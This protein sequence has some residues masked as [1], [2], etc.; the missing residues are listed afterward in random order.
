ML[1]WHNFF[2]WF[3]FCWKRK[4]REFATDKKTHGKNCWFT[5]SMLYILIFLDFWCSTSRKI[6][7]H[8]LNSHQTS[9]FSAFLITNLIK[10][11]S[12]SL[13]AFNMKVIFKFGISVSCFWQ[14]IKFLRSAYTIYNASLYTWCSYSNS[15]IIYWASVSVP[16]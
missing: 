10:M 6:Q 15:T 9:L 4:S 2:P 5:Y 12:D 11:P 8:R 1:I 3:L 13:S 14:K 16:L 7:L